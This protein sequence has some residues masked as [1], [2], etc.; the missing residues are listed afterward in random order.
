[1]SFIRAECK[2]E[3]ENRTKY[4]IRA[5]L[6]A[7]T[8]FVYALAVQRD[9]LWQ[10]LHNF[11]PNKQK[12]HNNAGRRIDDLSK[13][14]KEGNAGISRSSETSQSSEIYMSFAAGLWWLRFTA[15]QSN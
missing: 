3:L 8:L 4:L 14:Q 12:A 15:A 13:W 9:A 2:D 1:M 6:S 7:E 10:A 5:A 11:T